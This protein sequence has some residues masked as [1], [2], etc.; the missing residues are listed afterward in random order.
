MGCP[1]YPK[2]KSR[3]CKELPARAAAQ[4]SGV[5]AAIRSASHS[6]SCL[7]SWSLNGTGGE[8]YAV[9]SQPKEAPRTR[10][11]RANLVEGV[12]YEARAVIADHMPCPAGRRDGWNAEG[13]RFSRRS[14]GRRI[15]LLSQ[16]RVLTSAALGGPS[17]P[18]EGH[19]LCSHCVPCGGYPSPRA[20]EG[21]Y[22]V[23]PSTELARQNGQRCVRQG[24][25]LR[26]SRETKGHQLSRRGNY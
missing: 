25:A 17:L 2:N 24:T 12:C 16:S 26:R 15:R 14:Y 10:C 9:V 3:T 21:P 13:K 22:E 20:G 23:S 4:I 6:H 19:R 18:S 7:C 1:R 11:R 8:N 5:L